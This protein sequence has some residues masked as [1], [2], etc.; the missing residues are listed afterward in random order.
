MSGENDFAEA[1]ERI[2]G[3]RKE[4]ER[5]LDALEESGPL[6][7]ALREQ[8]EL[9]AALARLKTRL[10]ALEPSAG[11]KARESARPVPEEKPAAAARREDRPPPPLP[12]REKKEADAPAP[13]TASETPAPETAPEVVPA[14]RAARTAKEEDAAPATEG[15]EMRV[16]T[17]WLV[18]IGVVMLL[19]GFAFLANYFRDMV[20]P[21][22]KVATLYLLSFGLLGAGAWVEKRR[23]GMLNYARVL[24]G[25]GLAA[26]YFTTYAAH[27]VPNL[28]VI[29][30]PLL[31]ALLLLL[32]AAVI[33]VLADRRRSQTLAVG[34]LLLAYYTTIIHEATAFSMVSALILA[35]AALVFLLRHRWS[36]VGFVSLAGHLPRLRLLAL[37]GG[38]RLGPRHR[39]GGRILLAGLRIP[40]LL[41]AGLHGRRPPARQAPSVHRAARHLRRHQQRRLSRALRPGHDPPPPDELWIFSL[42][43]AL[44]LF[45]L[46]LV[47][48]HR[49]GGGNLLARIALAKGLFLLTLAFL[50]KLTGPSLAL[51]LAAESCALLVL[52]RRSQGRPSSSSAPSQ[53]RVSRWASPSQPSSRDPLTT[54][55]SRFPRAWPGR[56]GSSRRFSCSSMR[57]GCAGT[58]RMGTARRRRTST[59]G[60]PWP[61][62][63]WGPSSTWRPPSVRS[64]FSPRRPR[65]PPSPPAR[66]SASGTSPL[67]AR[68]SLP[69]ERSPSSTVTSRTRASVSRPPC[70]RPSGFSSSSSRFSTGRGEAPRSPGCSMPRASSRPSSR[71]FCACL[72]VFLDA[73]D[74]PVNSWP[75]LGGILASAL[76]AWA[77][78]A[79]VPWLAVA[80]Q[81]FHFAAVSA[82]TSSSLPTFTALL[83]LLF[84]LANT[85]VIARVLARNGLAVDTG[86]R[87][88]AL[89]IGLF[90]LRGLAFIALIDFVE[91]EVGRSSEVLVFAVAVLATWVAAMRGRSPQLQFFAHALLVVLV[92]HLV[93]GPGIAHR[94][95]VD[96]YWRPLLT[97]LVPF[98]M[99]IVLRRRGG[100]AVRPEVGAPLAFLEDPAFHRV[101]HWLLPALGTVLTWWML[102]M[103]ITGELD[104]RYLALGWSILAF[105]LFAAGWLLRERSY[106]LYS[107]GLLAAALLRILAFD[108]WQLESLARILSFIVIGAVLLALGFVYNRYQEKLKRYFT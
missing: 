7:D 32:W 15:L 73:R 72:G 105:A 36:V 53:P 101:L 12:S 79:H 28:Q 50:L 46:C 14:V 42:V 75:W 74:L 83:P 56:S 66:V 35:G 18:R 8:A 71:G 25:G 85:A 10:A 82:A 19:T 86:A 4:L 87:A 20:G 13:E 52:A 90:A 108:V 100:D 1:L 98:A 54:S 45:A 76:L 30:S 103:N 95:G 48:G 41:L 59:S 34:G 23:P 65:A 99:Q 26:V 106:R 11:S 77:L 60:S 39:A 51:A 3:D 38:G 27:R 88:S 43:S 9:R 21:E 61:R 93:D 6:R 104:S 70:S 84:L 94:D 92:M 22:T 2:E 67:P 29:E 49:F 62:A 80:S 63:P 107:L 58:T 55:S 5:R 17:Y 81:G 64:P 47:S 68:F 91:D 102:S 44:A 37:P 97:C 89:R 40:A 57:G 78:L 31:A 69:L 24:G 16:G 96:L 33:V